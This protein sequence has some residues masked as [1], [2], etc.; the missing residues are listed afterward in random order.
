MFRLINYAENI[1][2]FSGIMFIDHGDRGQLTTMSSN[3]YDHS[4]LK[5]IC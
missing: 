2:M 4:Y 1:W 3:I 5:G